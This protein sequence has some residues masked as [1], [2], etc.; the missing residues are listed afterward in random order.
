MKIPN[1]TKEKPYIEFR[2]DKKG[3]IKLSATAN[4]WGGKK[5][6]FLSPDGSEGN[7]CVPKD[8]KLYI[9]AFKNR[10]IK[11]IEKEISALQKQLNVFKFETD[12]WDF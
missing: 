11:K 6:S 2:I 3:K 7:T 5:G 9:K 10:K 8:L 4:Y 1:T 12:N